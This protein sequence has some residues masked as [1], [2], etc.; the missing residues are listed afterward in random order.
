MSISLTEMHYE[1]L[2]ALSE[3]KDVSLAWLIRQAVE[4]YI[5]QESNK[6]I[7]GDEK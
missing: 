4:V 1:Q 7:K 6:K 2:C 5:Q 3:K